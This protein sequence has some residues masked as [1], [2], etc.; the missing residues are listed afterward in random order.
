MMVLKMPQE[1]EELLDESPKVHNTPPPMTDGI[2]AK[3]MLPNAGIVCNGYKNHPNINCVTNVYQNMTMGS[4][5]ENLVN[6]DSSQ[7][8]SQYTHL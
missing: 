6:E 2:S 4:N 3:E 7:T 5:F 8:F 1:F